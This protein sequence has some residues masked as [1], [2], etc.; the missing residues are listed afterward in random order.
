MPVGT[1]LFAVADGT[2]AVAGPGSPFACPVLNN[3]V[4]TGV[5]V[6]IEH[7]VL[8]PSG[9]ALTLRS[10]YS[11]LSRVDVTVGQHVRAGEQIGLSG[12]A[13]CSTAPHLHFEV[14]RFVSATRR[15]VTMDPYGWEGAGPDPW[16]LDARG[17]ASIWLWR[18]A[19]ALFKEYH[20][21]ANSPSGNAAAAVTAIRWLGYRDDLNP[22]NEFV[23]ISLD[24]RYAPSGVQDMTGYTI[25]NG[26]DDTYTFPAGARLL[27]DRPIRVYSGSGQNTDITL[28]WGRASGVWDNA[29][30]CVRLVTPRGGVYRIRYANITCS[31]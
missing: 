31:P 16:A 6:F 26:K 10:R 20:Q 25:R 8:A 28:Y 13:G 3:A 18:D 9:E 5:D 23:E 4:V 1:P 22:N 24:P 14:Y 11:H 30:D 29:G 7:R 12:N 15:F 17:A 21:A 19:P 2:V 27:V